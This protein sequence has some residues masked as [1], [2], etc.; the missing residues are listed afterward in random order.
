MRARANIEILF[1]QALLDPAHPFTLEDLLDGL[2]DNPS[3]NLQEFVNEL[4]DLGSFLQLDLPGLLGDA[5]DNV[6]SAFDSAAGGNVDLVVVDLILAYLSLTPIVAEAISI[7]LDLLGPDL[8]RVTTSVLAKSLNAATGPVISGIGKTGVAIQ[9]IITALIEDPDPGA[10][11]GA[12]IDPPGT[13]AYGVFNGFPI[14][15]SPIAFPGTPGDAFDP[16]K[17]NPG[18]VSLAIGLAQGLGRS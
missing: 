4:E 2:L 6:R 11:L 5:A 7:P 15:P 13:I 16:T 12:L 17:P 9:N 18:P 10:L 1:L 8:A 14:V 3:A